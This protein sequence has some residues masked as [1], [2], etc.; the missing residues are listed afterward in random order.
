M[1][2]VEV[3]EKILLDAWRGCYWEGMLKAHAS[4]CSLEPK[5][6]AECY[7]LEQGFKAVPCY[8]AKAIA[9]A[10]LRLEL[11]REL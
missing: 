1:A 9:E 10:K 6:C 4:S 5:Q 8:D 7:M 3:D 11:A 2:T